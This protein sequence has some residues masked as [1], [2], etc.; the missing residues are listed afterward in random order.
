MLHSNMRRSTRLTNRP[1]YYPKTRPRKKE[2]KPRRKRLRIDVSV[3][4]THYKYDTINGTVTNYK[5]ER[6]LVAETG[7]YGGTRAAHTMTLSMELEKE[8]RGETARFYRSDTGEHTT[9]VESGY[10]NGVGY[11]AFDEAKIYLTL[12]P[13][14]LHDEQIMEIAREQFKAMQRN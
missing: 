13:H 14:L 10:T 8:M 11:A 6:V 2:T 9:Q 3:D 1:Q 5:G 7:G 4:V 12:D